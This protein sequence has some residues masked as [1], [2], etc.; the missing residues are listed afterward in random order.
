MKKPIFAIIF[1]ALFA[2]AYI[3]PANAFFYPGVA[4]ADDSKSNQFGP[5]SANLLITPWGDN[6]AEFNA[7]LACDAD[8]MDW[9]LDADQ[10]AQLETEDPNMNTFARVPY[11]D[12]G[13]REL[14]LNNMRFPFSDPYFRQAAS[15]CIDKNTFIANVLGGLALKMDSPLAA[16]GAYY[17]PYCDDLYAFNALFTE[18]IA[19]LD[20]RGY[21]D[22]DSD[23][24]REGP[25]EEEIFL[26]CYIRQD[27]PIRTAMGLQWCAN[28]ESIGI[29]CDEHVVPRTE[30]QDHAM[31]TFDY[32][33]YTGGWSFGRDPTTLYFLYYGEGGAQ[34][35]PWCANYPGYNN[36]VWDA[37]ADLF[38]WASEV[39]DGVTPC[40]AMY[41]AW[42]MQQIMMDEACIIPVF[43]FA[44][45]GSYKSVWEKVSNANGVGP[46]GWYSFLNMVNDI[47]STIDWAFMNDIVQFNPIH[48]QWVW[49]WNLMSEVYDTLVNV[50]PYTLADQPWI[51]SSWSQGTWTYET[52]ECTW[53]E[54][55]I[56]E[57]VYWQDVEPSLT[58]ETPKHVPLL[59]SGAFNERVMADDVVFSIMAVKEIADSWNHDT[60][61]DVIYA[62]E[63]DPFTVKVYFGVYMP[64]WAMHQV[65]GLP[66]IPK[67]VWYPVYVDNETRAFDPIA[68]R[69]AIGSG[70]FQYDYDASTMGE[71]Y[72]LRAY[73]RYAWYHP[74]DVIGFVAN[75]VVNPCDT[76]SIDFFL[77]NR[78]AQREIMPPSEYIITITKT[79]P[80]ESVVVLYE[81]SNP[82]LP[83][84]EWVPIFHY[85][86]HI[87]R[88]LYVI[89][90]TI[91]PDPLTGHM[92]VDGYPVDIWG[93]IPEDINLD[94]YVNAK[95]AVLL[96]KAFGTSPGTVAWSPA[97]DING[98]GYVN[99]KDAVKLG[100]KFGW[101][102]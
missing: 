42:V 7:F 77:H 70:P 22:S 25:A 60:V 41:H 24:W 46:W 75:K 47:D 93:T 100:I 83:F 17:N 13:M 43:T 73:T 56:R 53:V 37:E 92:D 1:V 65:A 95:D 96:G 61:A 57:D 15:Y 48:S 55:K 76:V 94:F 11:F 99:A 12:R 88:G 86:E 10:T 49:D 18:A 45:Y 38:W 63:V 64:L 79:Y 68:Q 44:S 54:F 89:K 102:S 85:E 67:H 33:M 2:I 51:A 30:C 27:D 5:M 50:D 21:V 78:D 90:A 26:E 39:G 97:A 58:R 40:T 35:Y 6:T 91:T 28:L 62:E 29:Q 19:I 4:P 82:P 81:D 74:V 71:Y 23:G 80:D 20:A 34:A 14:D 3:M 16:H 31:V 72:M 32:D 69:C 9:A 98:D 84:C 59:R 87:D 66:I 36:P 52:E 101:P 8:I